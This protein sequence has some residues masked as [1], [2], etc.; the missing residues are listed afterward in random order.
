MRLLMLNIQSLHTVRNRD[1]LVAYNL[2]IKRRPTVENSLHLLQ[3]LALGLFHEEPDQHGHD[4]VERGVEEE[5][6]TTPGSLHVGGDEGE[7]EVEEPLCG[8]GD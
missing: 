2:N 6:I 3:T 8:D 4:N 1:T 7:K 5:S